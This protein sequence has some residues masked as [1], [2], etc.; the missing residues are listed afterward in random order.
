METAAVKSGSAILFVIMF[1][2][3]TIRCQVF[4]LGLVVISVQLQSKF[5]NRFYI[6]FFSRYLVCIR[7][8]QTKTAG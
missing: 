8:A 2:E 1:E 4:K 6:N 5:P 3:F 7:N